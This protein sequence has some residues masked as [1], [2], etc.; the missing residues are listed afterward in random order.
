MVFYMILFDKY[1]FMGKL[2]LDDCILFCF[3]LIKNEVFVSK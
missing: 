1:K 2:S 3:S